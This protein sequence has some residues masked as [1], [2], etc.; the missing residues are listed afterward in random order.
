MEAPSREPVSSKF[1]CRAPQEIPL[2]LSLCIFL[3]FLLPPQIYAQDRVAIDVK[4]TTG[5]KIDLAPVEVGMTVCLNQSDWANVSEIGEDYSLWLKSYER[6]KKGENTEA[7]LTLELRTP[8]FLRSGSLIISRTVATTFRTTSD[9]MVVPDTLHWNQ[10]DLNAVREAIGEEIYESA[11]D[12]KRE[13]LIVGTA[14]CEAARS[15][16]EQT[17]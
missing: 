14:T 12:L 2:L 6:I 5:G 10:E 3:L 17:R 9:G 8:A 7:R 13:A 15:L 16:V 11:S 1:A 4:T